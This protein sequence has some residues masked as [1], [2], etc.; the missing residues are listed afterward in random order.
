MACRRQHIIWTNAGILL[1]GPLGTNFSDI[2]IEIRAFFNQRNAFENGSLFVQGE[3]SNFAM[4]CYPG[5]LF[6]IDGANPTLLVFW[7]LITVLAETAHH[8]HLTHP[9]SSLLVSTGNLWSI[10]VDKKTLLLWFDGIL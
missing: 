3:M 1:I 7:Y 10:C 4:D 8:N 6:E 5:R 9:S 2:W